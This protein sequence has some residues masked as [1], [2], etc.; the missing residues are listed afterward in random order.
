MTTSASYKAFFG[1]SGV[2]YEVVPTPLTTALRRMGRQ[3]PR[4]PSQGLVLKGRP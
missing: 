2:H 3:A 1:F 4:R